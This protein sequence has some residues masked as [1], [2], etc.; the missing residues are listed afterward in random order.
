M[1]LAD[2]ICWAV[3]F[4]LALLGI[5]FGF[6]ASVQ[7]SRANRKIKELISS[8]WAVDEAQRIFFDNIKTISLSNGQSI[9]LLETKKKLTYREYAMHSSNG[10]LIPLSGKVIE[11]IS[12]TEFKDLAKTYVSVKKGLDDL[13]IEV[14]GGDF[15]IL[16]E[17]IEITKEMRAKLIKYH[18]EVIHNAKGIIRQYNHILGSTESISLK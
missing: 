10:R 9:S 8:S 15:S 6:I 2:I 5:L 7:S 13:F 1:G 17:N 11:V 16:S 14:I 3:S 18:N 4:A 12:E